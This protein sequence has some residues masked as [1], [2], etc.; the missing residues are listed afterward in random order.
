MAAMVNSDFPND[1]S[2]KVLSLIGEF[3]SLAR[4]ILQNERLNPLLMPMLRSHNSFVAVD[5][6]TVHVVYTTEGVNSAIVSGME[7]D[8][9]NRGALTQKQIV[10]GC[11]RELAYKDIHYFGFPVALLDQT[12][13]AR[14]ATIEQVIR[15]YINL[16]IQPLIKLSKLGL[17]ESLTYLSNAK[18]RFDTKT[19]E[20]YADC[21]S[22]CRNAMVSCIKALTDQENLKEGA[23]ILGKKGLIGEREEELITV[24]GE[25]LAK[26]HNLASKK[27]PHP[28]L[29]NDE[30]DAL[31]VLSLTESI[32]NYIATKV[33]KGNT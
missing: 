5:S 31:L 32:L 10:E 15:Q 26:L 14:K 8:L 30:E 2:Q 24:F 25:L 3:T 1:L 12:K 4:E 17:S 19:A 11:V 9:R 18:S 23:K 28:P 7:R 21:K 29:S 13:D 6:A 22:N 16:K 27:G 33:L 20:G